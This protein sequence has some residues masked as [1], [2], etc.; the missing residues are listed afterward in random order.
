MLDLREGCRGHRGY[1]DVYV[2]GHNNPRAELVALSVKMSQGP[3]DEA[4]NGGLPQPTLADALIQCGF[5]ALPTLVCCIRCTMEFLFPLC[6]EMLWQTVVQTQNHMDGPISG[7]PVRQI[8]ARMPTPFLKRIIPYCRRPACRCRQD[9]CVTIR[10]HC[11][12]VPSSKVLSC[13]A[14]VRPAGAGRMPALRF[15]FIV[16]S[17]LRQK[18]CRVA[19]A[20]RLP[21]QA[22][23]LRY[24]FALRNPPQPTALW[25]VGHIFN[26]RPNSCNRAPDFR[27][28]SHKTVLRYAN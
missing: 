10:F 20:A 16:V 4:G 2:V 6:Q 21:V 3:G 28:A 8:A 12:F 23:C 15:A 9:A 11:C 5:N 17:S 19:Q 27:C 7:V 24:G 14:G 13:S 25:L 18:C 22:R 1:E 26:S